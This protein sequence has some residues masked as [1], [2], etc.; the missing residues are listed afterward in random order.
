MNLTPACSKVV[1]LASFVRRRRSARTRGFTVEK[2]KR[3]V[4]PIFR[5]LWP[6][7]RSPTL[8]FGLFGIF[9]LTLAQ[10]MMPKT[11]QENFDRTNI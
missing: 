6:L 4:Q 7:A 5:T 2:S 8:P 9:S 1:K 10:S 11:T 3:L